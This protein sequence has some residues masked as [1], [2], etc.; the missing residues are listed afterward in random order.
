MSDVNL[1]WYHVISEESSKSAVDHSSEAT[2]IVKLRS[3]VAVVTG[4]NVKEFGVPDRTTEE[5]EDPVE[6]IEGECEDSDI[7]SSVKELDVAAVSLLASNGDDMVVSAEKPRVVSRDDIEL[8][9]VE[10]ISSVLLD[11]L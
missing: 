3:K 11:L 6:V 1:D 7:E 10:Y 8:L 5:A 9:G 4:G 2:G